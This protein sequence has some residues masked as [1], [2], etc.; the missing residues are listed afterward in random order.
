MGCSWIALAKVRT[1]LISSVFIPKDKASVMESRSAARALQAIA[2]E[3][4]VR[5]I[6]RWLRLIKHSSK[7]IILNLN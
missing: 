5:T 6:V 7:I 4:C 2:A 1:S 3:I